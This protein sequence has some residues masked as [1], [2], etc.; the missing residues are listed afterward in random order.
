MGIFW[1]LMDLI[2]QDGELIINEQEII[3][4]DINITRINCHI[5]LDNSLADCQVIRE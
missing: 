1:K 5:F 3:P 4:T 2:H